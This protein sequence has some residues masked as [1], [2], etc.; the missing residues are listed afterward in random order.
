M[1]SQIY[2]HD[3]VQGLGGTS[4]EISRSCKAITSPFFIVVV[5]GGVLMLLLMRGILG[6]VQN[7]CKKGEVPPL[8]PHQ[9]GKVIGVECCVPRRLTFYFLLY[10]SPLRVC[11]KGEATVVVAGRAHC[12]KR[13]QTKQFFQTFRRSFFEPFSFSS[14][15]QQTHALHEG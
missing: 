5:G 8:T 1:P 13:R 9:G 15:D 2:R 10:L 3:C 7:S 11:G 12:L 4:D 14:E 6:K